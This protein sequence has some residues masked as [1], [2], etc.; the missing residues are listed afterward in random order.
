MSAEE[1]PKPKASGEGGAQSAD[2]SKEDGSKE[3]GSKEDDSKGKKDGGE[4]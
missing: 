3:D 1:A 4:S 2:G